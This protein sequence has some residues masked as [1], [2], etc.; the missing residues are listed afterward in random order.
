[1]PLAGPDELDDDDMD[2]KLCCCRQHFIV[3][4]PHELGAGL[5]DDLQ[6]LE[7]DKEREEDP[8]I[9]KMLLETLFQVHCK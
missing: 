2:G 4:D 7:D 8:E 9:R 5:P 1:M 6:F 3:P